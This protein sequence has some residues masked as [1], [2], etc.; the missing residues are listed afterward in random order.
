M[1]KTAPIPFSFVIDELSALRPDVKRAFGFTYVY[2]GDRLLCALR[3]SKKQFNSN[4]I[5]L[6]TTIDDVDSLG[7]E[8]PEL[9][10][11]NLWRSKKNAWVVLPSRSVMFEEYAFKA[12]ELILNGDRRIGRMSKGQ[13][14]IRNMNREKPSL[15]R[16]S[17]AKS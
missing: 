15:F 5:W 4:G 8:F 6:F 10:R 12:C 7:S 16:N 3:D 14:L 11:R 9:S 17:F 2:L 13:T 1:T